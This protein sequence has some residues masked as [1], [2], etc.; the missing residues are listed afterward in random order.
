MI[1]STMPLLTIN[2]KTEY[3]YARPVA[4][5]EHRIMLR[6][7]Q[8]HDLHVLATQLLIEPEPMSLRWIHDVFGNS[9]AIATFDERADTLTFTATSTVEHNPAEDF[10]LTTDD[11]AFF[12]PFFYLLAVIKKPGFRLLT[13]C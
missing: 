5:G 9:V 1:A 8:G 4:F 13:I 10:A 12:Y 6:P 7:L 3:R 11:H 2:H